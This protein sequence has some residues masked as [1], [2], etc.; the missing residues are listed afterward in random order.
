MTLSG[1]DVLL[2]GQSFQ[3][4]HGLTERL[5]RWGFRC[6]FARNMR[7]AREL[8]GSMRVDVVL[9]D[10]HL[11]D[12]TGI[13]LLGILAGLAVTAFLCLPVESSCF[14]LPA[15]DAG[16]KCLGSPALRPAE[17]ARALEEMARCLG[18]AARG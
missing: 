8:L 11:A 12:G 6:H 16:K 2:V 13:T 7:T 9:S 17:F 1:R 15:I 14:W 3:T 4:P 18:A 5:Q 10:M